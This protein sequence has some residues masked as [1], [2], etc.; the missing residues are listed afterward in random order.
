MTAL[1]RKIGVFGAG[2]VGGH[3]AARLARA[4][5]AVSVVARGPH[6]DAIRRQGLRLITHDDDF[7]VQVAASDR[8]TDLGPQDLVISTVKAQGLPAAAA[9]L[10]G[11]LGPDTPVVFAVNGIPWWYLHGQAQGSAR[12]LS[13]LDPEQS[14]RR[15]IGLERVL[16]CV[17]R[18]PNEIIE[19]GVVRSSSKTSRFII[20]EIDGSDSQRLA[21]VVRVLQTGLPGAE[22]TTDIRAAI[23]GKLLVNLASSL[24]STLTLSTSPD[25]FANAQT[26]DLY[27][28]IAD[29]GR[30]V[31][32]G[33]GIQAPF[34]LQ[35]QVSAAG[36]N[37]HPPSMMQDLLAGRPLELDAQ[38]RAVQDLG[39]QVGV[40]TPL[41]D[42][43]EALL[44]QRVAA[45]NY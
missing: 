26:R 1:P 2:A 20:G 42:V 19:P 6:L 11:L 25:L 39:A 40:A 9:Q 24:L 43:L 3:V 38:I 29:E 4:G 13:R 27:Q 5:L 37:R 7:T 23:W 34:D 28:R 15:E 41:I 17:I 45:R 32:A 44:T 12:G 16:G 10:A 18:S 8:A 36:Q 14:L 21:A 35:A 33:L 22:A 31:A 30:A